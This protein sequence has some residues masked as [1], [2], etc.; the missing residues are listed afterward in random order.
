MNRSDQTQLIVHYAVKN[1]HRTFAG[2]NALDL[3]ERLS[4]PHEEVRAIVEQL[5]DEGKGSIKRDVEVCQIELNPLA[6]HA[7][8]S[9]ELVKTHV[10]F[11]SKEL[12]HA[13]FYGSDLA[14][15][16]L[17]EYQRRMHLGAKQLDL[18]F[19]SEEVLARY[20]SHPEFYEVHDSLA[21]GEITSHSAAPEDRQLYVLYGK[22]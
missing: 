10:Y 15:R 21:G 9:G 14:K 18:V 6:P 1:W 12:L 3:A 20:L 8:L 22:S 2:T 7:D 13:D 11:P 19:F 17:P 4:I 5:C 16:N